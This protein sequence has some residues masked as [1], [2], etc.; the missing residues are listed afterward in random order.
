MPLF[1]CSFWFWRHILV[2]SLNYHLGHSQGCRRQLTIA[3][4]N[5][6]ATT[7]PSFKATW[8]FIVQ[9]AR[10]YSWSHLSSMKQRRLRRMSYQSLQVDWTGWLDGKSSGR[11]NCTMST[12]GANSHYIETLSPSLALIA[13]CYCTFQLLNQMG[14]PLLHQ[15]RS[16]CQPL[17]RTIDNISDFIT[18]Q[19]PPEQWQ[20]QLFAELFEQIVTYQGN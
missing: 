1:I 5:Y 9:Q 10:S 6:V 3:R 15:R 18:Y 4:P 14:A 19:T 7:M 13:D 8:P 12:F 11:A 2:S 17:S 20:H 16:Y